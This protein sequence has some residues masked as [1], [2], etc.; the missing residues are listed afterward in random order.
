MLHEFGHSVY[1]S[2]TDNIPSTLPYALRMESHILTTEGVAMMFE[3]L[4]SRADFLQKMGMSQSRT[5][6]GSTATPPC[7]CAIAC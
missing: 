6:R 4:A 1:S 2:N 7:R 5:R 3:R